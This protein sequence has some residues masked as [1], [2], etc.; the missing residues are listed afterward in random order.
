MGFELSMWNMLEWL[1][2]FFALG[3]AIVMASKK[4]NHNIAWVVWLLSNIIFIAIFL[5]HT[6]QMGL[7]FMQIAGLF[8]NIFGFY[9]NYKGIGNHNQHLMKAFFLLS[10]VLLVCSIFFIGKLFL[11]PTLKNVEWIGSLLGVSAALLIS[12][13]HKHSRYCWILWTLGNLIIFILT[14][15]T[16]QY[17]YMTLQLGFSITNF[18]GVWN[19]FIK[20]WL[21]GIKTK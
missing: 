16:K 17:G 19:H 6:Q 9:Q 13:Y 8:I 10:L 20:P 5:V 1:G 2:T 15:Y 21:I 7:L 18:Y 3:G 12:S 11:E 14:L 4:Y